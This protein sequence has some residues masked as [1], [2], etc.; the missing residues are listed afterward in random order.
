[1]NI[2]TVFNDNSLYTTKSFKLFTLK[3]NKYEYNEE[4]AKEMIEYLGLDTGKII[5]RCN[6]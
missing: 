2:E 5:T 3:D 6:S 4:T 1:M